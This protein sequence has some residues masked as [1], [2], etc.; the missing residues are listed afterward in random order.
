MK[1]KTNL[2]WMFGIV[3]WFVVTA[4][5]GQALAS[6]FTADL[7][8]QYGDHVKSGKIYVKGSKYCLDLV[9]D[10][11]QIIVIVDPDA[12]RTIVISVSMK[13][14]QDLAIDDMTSVMND[15]IQGYAYTAG[16]GEEKNAGTET[17]NGFECDKFVISM[18]DTDVMSK[19]VSKKLGFPIKII[20]HGPPDRIME[21]TNIKEGSIDE[22]KFNI[23]EGFT[24]WIDPE[25][26]PVE[27]PEWAAGIA[28]APVMKPP[29]EHDMAAGDIVRITVELGKSL[30][31]KSENK[32]EANAEAKV[33]PFKDGRPLKKESWYNN[34]AQK[35]V[36]CDRRHE[37]M[38]EADEFVIY[39][40]EGNI[41]TIAKWQEMHERTVAAGDEIRLKLQGFDNIKTHLVNISDGESVAIVSYYKDGA[42]LSDDELGP[43]KWRTITLKEPNEVDSRTMVPKGDEI[44]FK[45]EQGKML[46]KL[47]QFDSF[48]F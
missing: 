10:G 15:P 1:A 12:K 31:I 40:Y 34:F 24:K 32:S 20:A 46:I 23:P 17:I 2:R 30:K 45:V 37:T 27:P 13:E 6:E 8:E 7:T 3:T 38:A 5:C 43:I 18:M 16:M 41:K 35:G 19:W 28:S 36:I 4:F 21:L 25:T 22:T 48:E 47:G 42:Q 14:Y 9:E 44:V 33:V 39:V 29:F 26:L 11:E